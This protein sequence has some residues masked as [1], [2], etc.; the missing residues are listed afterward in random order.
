MPAP[1]YQTW[2]AST[3]EQQASPPAPA[4]WRDPLSPE[5]A[6]LARSGEACA[7]KAGLSNSTAD[8][9]RALSVLDS[10]CMAMTLFTSHCLTARAGQ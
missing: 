10:A 2:S 7:E 3:K 6:V 1:G 8:E 4:S 5:S 9:R